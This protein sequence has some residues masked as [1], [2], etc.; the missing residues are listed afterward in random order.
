MKEFLTS[1]NY[2]L[3]CDKIKPNFKALSREL[4]NLSVVKLYKNKL[5]LNN[6]F[7]FGKMDIS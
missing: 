4:L 3:S 2:G 7:V 5:Y 6:G 1:L